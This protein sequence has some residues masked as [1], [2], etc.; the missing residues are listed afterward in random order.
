MCRQCL[1]GTSLQ[2]SPC[3]VGQTG[4]PWAV[5][6]DGS[7]N[8]CCSQFPSRTSCSHS[9]AVP[10]DTHASTHSSTSDGSLSKG[11][12]NEISRVNIKNRET[13][14]ARPGKTK[15]IKKNPQNS[16]T[17]QCLRPAPCSNQLTRVSSP[18]WN[19]CLS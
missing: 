1:D 11:T 19:S 10:V 8:I 13:G 5:G 16:K 12:K 4:C 15:Q 7:G 18:D 3:Q 6:A 14:S 17:P 9:Q 2:S